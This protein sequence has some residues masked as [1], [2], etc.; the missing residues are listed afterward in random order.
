MN[1]AKLKLEVV[2]PTSIQCGHIGWFGLDTK[3]VGKVKAI[4]EENKELK[5]ELVAINNTIDETAI[6]LS[7]CLKISQNVNKEIEEYCNSILE[8][9]IDVSDTD[10]DLGQYGVARD[11]KGKLDKLKNVTFDEILKGVGINEK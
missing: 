6:I 3:L 8:K 9:D 10:F 7:N 4:L 1:N 5:K 11:I 2:S